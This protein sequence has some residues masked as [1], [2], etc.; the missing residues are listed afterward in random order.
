MGLLFYATEKNGTGQ[1]LWDLH[2]KLFPDYQ[3]DF[4]QTIGILS[5]KL[6]HP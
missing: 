2:Q 5:Q 1:L 3:G 4:Y 6:R